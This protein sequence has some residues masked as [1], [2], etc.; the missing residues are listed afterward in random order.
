[1][2]AK[3]FKN[4]YS[5]LLKHCNTFVKNREYAN[6]ASGGV[7]NSISD[8]YT[9]EILFSTNIEAVAVTINIPKKSIFV[10]HI[11]LIVTQ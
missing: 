8:K 2:L 1:M 3:N 9:L 10:T 6:H 4:N 5:S 7:S 11:F